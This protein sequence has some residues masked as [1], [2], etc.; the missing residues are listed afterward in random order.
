MI[1]ADTSIWI[2]H[3]REANYLLSE[4]LLRGQVSTHRFILGELACGN[5]PSRQQTLLYFSNLPMAATCLDKEV[6]FLI[7][8]H[9]LMGTGIGYIDAH[10]LASAIVNDHKLWTTDK[11]LEEIAC[12]L[13]VGFVE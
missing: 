7:E 10:L 2:R 1:L 3:F 4:E 12:S 6:M 13:N 8:R 5:L 9:D 11:R